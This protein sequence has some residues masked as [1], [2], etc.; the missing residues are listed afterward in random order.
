MARAIHLIAEN[1]PLGKVY[2]AGPA[3]PTAIHRVVELCAEVLEM[4]FSELCEVADDRLGQDGCYWLDSSAIK[5]DIGWEPT[6]DWQTGLNEV[7]EWV[8][9][10]FSQIAKLDTAYVFRG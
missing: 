8:D 9:R 7:K 1:A 5:Q 2:N 3:E 6:V 4:P 10:Y